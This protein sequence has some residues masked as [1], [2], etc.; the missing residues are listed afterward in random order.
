MNIS[1]TLH[2]YLDVDNTVA[3]G[4][5][6]PRPLPFG[7]RRGVLADDLEDRRGSFERLGDELRVVDRLTQGA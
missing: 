2:R 5:R 1:E 3:C 7:L 4:L 6:W